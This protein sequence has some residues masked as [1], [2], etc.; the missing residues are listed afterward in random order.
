MPPTIVLVGPASDDHVAALAVRVRAAGVEALVLDPA[1]F[2][3]S[4]RLTL[5]DDLDD[6]AINR[7]RLRPAAVYVRDPDLGGADRGG[8]DVLT[9]LV[10][11]WE[12]AGVPIYNGLLQRHRAARPLQRALLRAAGLP[13]PATRWTNDPA[14]V[15]R[16]AADRRA[17]FGPIA[18]RGEAREVC[19]RDLADER[20][21][22]LE[23]A[24]VSMQE[25]LPGEAVR[26]HVLDGAVVAAIRTV[27][28]TAVAGEELEPIALP[29]AV[30]QQ[31]A[32][33]AEVIGVRLAG[34]DLQRDGEGILRVLEVDPAPAFLAIDAGAGTDLAARIATRLV[35][36]AAV[37]APVAVQS[38]RSVGSPRGISTVAG[39]SR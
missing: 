38:I 20:L 28:P 15:R 1:R 3:E 18:G 10:Q 19:D 17:A 32:R 11:R 5:G 6:V 22:A 2:P 9:A 30:E 36:A 24:P 27:P 31:C 13:V 12:L 14:E 21:E 35:D 34:V 8:V 16:F 4:L 39:A 33:A 7:H 37:V 25:L 26:V 23:S 29:P